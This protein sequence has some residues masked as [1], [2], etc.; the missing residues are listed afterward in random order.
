MSSTPGRT[1]SPRTRWST[2]TG[3]EASPGATNCPTT[4]SRGASADAAR[5]LENF[6]PT[7]PAK[8]TLR[9]V[10][11]FPGQGESD[12]ELSSAQPRNISAGVFEP[13]HSL[14]RSRPP[15]TSED[16]TAKP[17][18][19]TRKVRRMID[20]GRFH[21]YSATLTQR[22]GRWIVSLTGVA[23]E[24]FRLAERSRTIRHALPV[25]VDRGISLLRG[26]CRRERCSHREL[27]GGENTEASA[28]VAQGGQPG[29]GQN[30]TGVQRSPTSEGP[31]RQATSQSRQHPTTSGPPS[32]Q[33]LG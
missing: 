9:R 3:L 28:R 29:P 10:P 21:V 18:G 6:A 24:F 17:C 16:R 20:A 14:H 1:E 2:T 26:S 12:A 30:H 25:G 23:A 7:W 5:S 32:L 15:A 33:G 31:A 4:F 8:W 27:R 13:A 22:A 19:P 11:P